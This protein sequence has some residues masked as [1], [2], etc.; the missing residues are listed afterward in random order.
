MSARDQQK[1]RAHVSPQDQDTKQKMH[2]HKTTTLK[3]QRTGP[4]TLPNQTANKQPSRREREPHSGSS[5]SSSAALNARAAAPVAA[6]AFLLRERAGVLPAES[7][8]N[9]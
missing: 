1:S 8:L 6:R 4:A 5:S 7:V 9:L 3:S 2:V